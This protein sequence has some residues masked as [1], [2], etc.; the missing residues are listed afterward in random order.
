ML[1]HVRD[2]TP[3]QALVRPPDPERQPGQHFFADLGPEDGHTV[4]A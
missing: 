1:D 3:G 4:H 2:A